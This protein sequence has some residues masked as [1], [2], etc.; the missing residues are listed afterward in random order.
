MS[1]M[2]L[3]NARIVSLQEALAIYEP[4]EQCSKGYVKNNENQALGFFIPIQDRF[5]QPTY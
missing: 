1:A 3:H 5:F 4:W 2:D